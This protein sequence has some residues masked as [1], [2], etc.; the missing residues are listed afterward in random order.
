MDLIRYSNKDSFYRRA[1]NNSHFS[2][3]DFNITN[4]SIESSINSIL[5]VNTIPF[6][7]EDKPSLNRICYI[8]QIINQE[9][10]DGI[11][12]S[13][14][15][16]Y[17]VPAII[18]GNVINSEQVSMIG[19]CIPWIDLNNIREYSRCKDIVNQILLSR[20]AGICIKLKT[21]NRY[22]DTIDLHTSLLA[23]IKDQTNNC[24]SFITVLHDEDLPNNN[25]GYDYMLG[26]EI[27]TG[28]YGGVI[29]SI[30]IC[31]TSSLS[32]A[33]A[34][35][36][37]TDGILYLYNDVYDIKYSS[38]LSHADNSYCLTN[39]IS[40]SDNA[41]KIIAYTNELNLMQNLISSNRSVI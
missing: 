19:N 3:Y 17:I 13:S 8:D 20:P 1:F 36:N 22:Y 9:D 7:V 28:L 15:D 30:Y 38:E 4:I 29:G 24:P 25:Y 2:S 12:L 35:I 34:K 40:N 39:S 33:I 5:D 11:L 23:V 18:N 26:K 10:V 41:I 27:Y 16:Y 31:H 37:S 14:F 32:D 21:S 6:L